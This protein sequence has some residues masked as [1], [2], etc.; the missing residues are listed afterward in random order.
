MHDHRRAAETLRSG[1][2]APTVQAAA[3]RQVEESLDVSHFVL[4]HS[5][6]FG[7]ADNPW[8]LIIE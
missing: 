5:E 8:C 6:S 7:E 2:L 1:H 3:G 4:V